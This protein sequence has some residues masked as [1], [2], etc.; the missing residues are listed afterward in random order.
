MPRRLVLDTNVVLDLLHFADAQAL[1]ILAAL[2]SGAAQCWADAAG[3]EELARVVTYPEFKLDATAGK[4]LC[5]RY[6]QLARIADGDPAPLSALPRCKDPDDQRFL[7]LAARTGAEML[8]TKD[9]ALL[10]LARSRG[11]GFRIVKPAEA[12]QEFTSRPPPGR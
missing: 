4:A 8:V 11:L 1:P 5:E 9:K 2:E 10:T 7:E 12:S 6:R 3:L